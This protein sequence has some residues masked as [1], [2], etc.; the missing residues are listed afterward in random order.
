MS[1][2]CIITLENILA[3]SCKVGCAYILWPSSVS[4]VSWKTC[5]RLFIAVG[6]NPNGR[7]EKINYT[8]VT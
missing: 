6:N 4:S 1:E 5:I 7:D 2:N 8:I 3:F